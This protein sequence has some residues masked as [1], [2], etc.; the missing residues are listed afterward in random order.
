MYRGAVINLK[1][2]SDKKPLERDDKDSERM[3]RLLPM[4]FIDEQ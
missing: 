3:H 4:E 1:Q 2:H